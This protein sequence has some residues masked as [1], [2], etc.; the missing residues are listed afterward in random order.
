V[1]L[2]ACPIVPF[3]P[4]Q[5]VDLAFQHRA[6]LFEMVQRAVTQVLSLTR[7]PLSFLPSCCDDSLGLGLPVLAVLIVQSLRDLVHSRCSLWLTCSVGDDPGYR[8]CGTRLVSLGLGGGLGGRLLTHLS[9]L[10]RAGFLCGGLFGL[11][12]LLL[13]LILRGGF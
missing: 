11:G 12:G 13:T 10:R 2:Q 5:L 1:A 7:E 3:E 4:R 9:E 6:F 8:R